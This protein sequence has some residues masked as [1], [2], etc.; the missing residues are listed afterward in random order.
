M[1]GAAVCRHPGG[2]AAMQAG[3]RDDSRYYLDVGKEHAADAHS[4]RHKMPHRVYDQAVGDVGLLQKD[5]GLMDLESEAVTKALATS[6]EIAPFVGAVLAQP[7]AVNQAEVKMFLNEQGTLS[8][9]VGISSECLDP[10]DPTKLKG[11]VPVVW[12]FYD[13]HH[14]FAARLVRTT[15]NGLTTDYEE[16]MVGVD[17][18][19][20]QGLRLGD[21]QSI[22][23]RA[24][25]SFAVCYFA[26]K[27]VQQTVSSE[28]ML[29]PEFV[30]QPQAVDEVGGSLLELKK[31]RRVAP[32][33]SSKAI[34]VMMLAVAGM[35]ALNF[36]YE[37]L[38]LSKEVTDNP[39]LDQ[40]FMEAVH[41]EQMRT[42][43]HGRGTDDSSGSDSGGADM[44]ASAMAGARG[45]AHVFSGLFTKQSSVTW[46]DGSEEP[47]LDPTSVSYL[48]PKLTDRSDVDPV[49]AE[50]GYKHD[51]FTSVTRGNSSETM[52]WSVE[53]EEQQSKFRRRPKTKGNGI[54]E[55][56]NILVACKHGNV[57]IS[58]TH[59]DA[60]HGAACYNV[61]CFEGGKTWLETQN[62]FVVSEQT[63]KCAARKQGNIAAT[64]KACR[65]ARALHERVESRGNCEEPIKL[66]FQ[67]SKQEPTTALF[68]EQ[69]RGASEASI[70]F[71]PF[72]SRHSGWSFGEVVL[73]LRG[74]EK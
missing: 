23:D 51:A 14:A 16:D 55:E 1:S 58:G 64:A 32:M 47:K 54:A 69:E 24:Q 43:L 38:D 62:D 34:S 31:G 42:L 71:D 11:D 53:M 13:N 49:S 73:F 6:S 46:A 10:D 37:H 45:S 50:F 21:L 27:T 28:K 61:E 67:G 30:A 60:F 2:P 66:P 39:S 57:C 22:T 41:E 9:H 56:E 44:P 8:W 33:L 29:M 72:D 5:K 68:F 15:I 52:I 63:K 26:C 17:K 35:A 40:Q 3:Y 7:Q 20:W 18:S 48:E 19:T 4:R 70:S 12:R 36:N 65:E 59:D 25:L 74:Q